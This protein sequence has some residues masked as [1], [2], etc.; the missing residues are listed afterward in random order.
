MPYPS[1]PRSVEF[2]VGEG[3]LG[4]RFLDGST[5]GELDLTVWDLGSRLFSKEERGSPG[6][7]ADKSEAESEDIKREIFS[8]WKRFW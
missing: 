1:P 5:G 8:Y 3:G 6:R 4:P 7:D 2:E